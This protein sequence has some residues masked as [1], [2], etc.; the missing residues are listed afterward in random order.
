V[1]ATDLVTDVG[2][3]LKWARHVAPKA[4]LTLLHVYRGLVESKLEWAGVP[5][6]DVLAHRLA[7]QR[8][9]ATRMT[10]LV[11]R[12]R[13]EDIRRALLAHGWPVHDVI[14]KARELGADLIVVAKSTCSWW[15]EVLGA[16]VSSEIATHADRDV[17][18]VHGQSNSTL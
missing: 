8:Q 3:A 4:S 5:Q 18:V 7:A 12:H 10:D 2:P 9:A 17:L 15:A 14:R 6:A 1:I 13:S 16:S 11:T